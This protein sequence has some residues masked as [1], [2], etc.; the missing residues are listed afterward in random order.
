MGIV[1]LRL[2]PRLLPKPSY[3]AGMVGMCDECGSR[4]I[5][6]INDPSYDLC[7]SCWIKPEFDGKVKP[8]HIPSPGLWKKQ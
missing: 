1:P 3:C 4:W 5:I 8:T 2:P 6:E 7:P